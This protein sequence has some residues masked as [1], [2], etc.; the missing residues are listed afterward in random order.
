MCVY[1][2]RYRERERERE[3]NKFIIN[4]NKEPNHHKYFLIL[5]NKQSVIGFSCEIKRKFY[6]FTYYDYKQKNFKKI[7]YFSK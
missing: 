4:N 5:N 7:K 1:E 2:E 3:N 6:C